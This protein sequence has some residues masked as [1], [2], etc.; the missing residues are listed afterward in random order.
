MSSPQA[1]RGGGRLFSASPGCLSLP[2]CCSSGERT[3]QVKRQARPHALPT[4]HCGWH[5][6]NKSP[7]WSDMGRAARSMHL[8][9]HAPGG[10][11]QSAAG[12]RVAAAWA[13][14]RLLPPGHTARSRFTFKCCMI[15]KHLLGILAKPGENRQFSKKAPVPCA[16]P[17][18]QMAKLENIWTEAWACS[19]SEELPKS[20]AKDQMRGSA[21]AQLS[22]LC[23]FSSRFTPREQ[24]RDQPGRLQGPVRGCS[25]SGPRRVWG[26]TARQHWNGNC[27]IWW[28]RLCLGWDHG[29]AASSYRAGSDARASPGTLWGSQPSATAQPSPVQ[30]TRYPEAA[31]MGEGNVLLDKGHV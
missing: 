5:P 28:E 18:L 4:S 21:S 2:A 8:A 23:D 3:Q 11:G 30:G 10:G 9:R 27:S 29:L 31:R 16:Q 24:K 1:L 12:G 19:K 15:F 26:F 25:P 13:A 14:C 17:V 7:T 20:K 22:W 6:W